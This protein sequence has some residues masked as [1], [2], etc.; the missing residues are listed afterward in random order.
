MKKLS[1]QTKRVLALILIL[2]IIAISFVGTIALKN[3]EGKGKSHETVGFSSDLQN[4]EANTGITVFTAD[5]SPNGGTHYDKV[6]VNVSIENSDG[7]IPS[8]IQYAWSDKS[9]IAKVSGWITL[10]NRQSFTTSKSETG[11]WYLHVKTEDGQT[12]KSGKYTIKS[13][14]GGSDS[15]ES[16]EEVKEEVVTFTP[17]K[18]E[19]WTKQIEVEASGGST[20]K[21]SKYQWVKEGETT[22]TSGWVDISDKSEVTISNNTATGKYYL[23]VKTSNGNSFS[24]GP[25]YIDNVVPEMGDIKF[26]PEYNIGINNE[27]VTV[28]VNATDGE[29]GIKE[30]SFNGWFGEEWKTTHSKV[31]GTYDSTNK[32]YYATFKFSDIKNT[33]TGETENGEGTYTFEAVAID[34]AGNSIDSSNINVV[35]D[36]TPPW[37]GISAKEDTT[38]KTSQKVWVSIGDAQSDVPDNT[39]ALMQWQTTDDDG[40]DGMEQYD[41]RK[42]ITREGA[43]RY[44]DFYKYSDDNMEGIYYL[45]LKLWAADGA[46]NGLLEYTHSGPYYIDNVAPKIV[47][48]ES[49]QENNTWINEEVTL[50]VN[51]TD[52]G[53]GIAEYSFD[54]GITWQESNQKI[55]TE[56]REPA[57]RVKDKAGNISEEKTYIVGIDKTKPTVRVTPNSAKA[58]KK[59]NV[60]IE[61]SDEGLSGLSPSNEY[62]YYLSESDVELIGGEWNDYTSGEEIN[63]LGEGKTGKY[64]LFIKAIKDKAGN[65][66]EDGITITIGEETYNRFGPY[67]FDNAA[68]T[69]SVNKT[70]DK[71]WA[72]I[73]AVTITVSDAESDLA[74][75]I[76][77]EFAWSTSD[78]S[79]PTKWE[80]MMGKSMSFITNVGLTGKYYLWIKPVNVKDIAGNV[81]TKTEVFGEYYLD[82]EAPNIVFEPNGNETWKKEHSIAVQIKELV[83]EVEGGA[84][85]KKESI[86]YIWS[87]EEPTKEEIIQGIYRPTINKNTVNEFS[88]TITNNIQTGNDWKVWMYVE[89]VLGNSRIVSSEVFYFDNEAPTI[90]IVEDETH[91][92]WK[93]EHNVQINISDEH[94]GLAI[95]SE[96]KYGWSISNNIEPMTWEEVTVSG[97]EEGA[98][99]A[100]FNIIE[101]QLVGRNYLWIKPSGVRDISL[102]NGNSQTSTLVSDYAFAFENIGEGNIDITFSQNGNTEWARTHSTTVTVTGEYRPSSL[103]YQWTRNTNQPEE[104]TFENE[105]TSGQ[106][107]SKTGATGELYLW[108]LAKDKDG[109]STIVHSNAFYLDNEGPKLVVTPSKGESSLSNVRINVTDSASGLKESN[110]YEYALINNFTGD[111]QISWDYYYQSNKLEWNEYNFSESFPIGENL[112]GEFYLIVKGVEDNAGNSNLWQAVPEYTPISLGENTEG[113]RAFGPYNFVNT[114]DLSVTM[115]PNGNTT[116]DKQQEVVILTNSTYALK[117]QKYL[118]TRESTI[119]SEMLNEFVVMKNNEKAVSPTDAEAGQDWYLWVYTEDI[120]GN[121]VLEKSSEFYIDTTVPTV[122]FTPNGNKTWSKSQTVEITIDDLEGSGINTELLKYLWQKE[123]TINPIREDISESFEN[124]EIVDGKIKATVT[125]DT[126]TGENWKLWIY[127]QD[128]AGNSRIIGS[129]VFAIDNTVPVAGTLT[130]KLENNDGNDYENNTWTTNNVYISVN[131]GSDEHSG[132]KTTVYSVN[133]G[134]ETTEPQ[135]LTEPGIYEIIVTTSDN[136]GN[137]ST[138]SY[139]V[140]IKRE[141]SLEIT[142]IPTQMEYEAYEDFKSK[143]MVISVIYDNGEKEETTDY[144]IINKENLT[145]QVI[146]IQIQYNKNPEIKVSLTGIKVNHAEKIGEEIEP[147]CTEKGKTAGKY[148]E[149]CNITLEGQNEIS[150][151]GHDY[152]QEITE[153]TCIE[154]GYTTNTCARCQDTYKSDETEALGHKFTNYISN[155][156]ATCTEDGTKTGKCENCDETETVTDEGSKL[157]HNYE[158][159]IVKP[160]CTEGGYTIYT[161]IRCQKTHKADETEALGH[162]FTNYISNNDA[163]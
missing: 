126:E 104:S 77:L 12:F 62:K 151:L 43:T 64:Y 94:S 130:M 122:E 136:A 120:Y 135:T 18:Q 63:S 50:T 129:E 91:R 117:E 144:T 158:T 69:I 46:K 60:I 1:K 54:N 102:D 103:K 20:C 11:Y 75:D 159:E 108:I 70:E 72:K 92:E 134:A 55:Y 67:V 39:N 26:T 45:G 99:I 95:G 79:V 119:T 97:Y 65:I 48:I 112:N 107:I 9:E 19:S 149:V 115:A 132:H 38:W 89:D 37:W 83:N 147:T 6:T 73:H 125:K 22:T 106:E 33:L 163:T 90:E 82:N 100:T 113:V 146:E 128:I 138:N 51:A 87:Q 110:I 7:S 155:N 21:I 148:C 4:S 86:K 131:N 36:N 31:S 44:F 66:S 145:C 121:I 74:D 123:S 88:G 57:I 140:K 58:C 35:Y 80:K 40:T 28:T 96:I 30:V 5:F 2:I 93:E 84:G 156:D 59:T 10:V 61:V 150:E 23:Y 32:R 118:W 111:L 124:I 98:N 27:E 142:S 25:Y 152:K 56:S 53:S 109:N 49:T 114:Q 68:P 42:E 71:N 153:P 41:E 139:T 143:G 34:N 137:I 8:V 16:E 133:G 14:S 15:G 160:T 85:I 81:T 162:K 24:S 116:W 157:G 29:S 101:N 13:S 3:L 47:D 76:E 52:G 154:K 141:T 161:C 78:K 127:V 17:K 105:F